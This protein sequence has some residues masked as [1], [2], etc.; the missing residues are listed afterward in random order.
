MRGV[1]IALIVVGV[2]SVA[3]RILTRDPPAP[4]PRSRWLSTPS[5]PADTYSLR[6]TS[7]PA[8]SPKSGPTVT[9]RRPT[10]GHPPKRPPRRAMGIPA[11]GEPHQA[12]A[13]PEPSTAEVRAWARANGIAVPERGRPSPE[14]W[15]AWR[16]EHGQGRHPCS[17]HIRRGH[18]VRASLR[19][20]SDLIRQLEEE[21]ERKADPSR[22][23][24]AP[25]HYGAPPARSAGAS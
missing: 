12:P 4:T 17:A 23:S 13:A 20:V 25:R 10:R 8:G 19:R 22:S 3:G 15:A 2:I 5:S 7:K 1:V 16:A 21:Q 11:P 18:D 24:P 14:V 9:S 6:Y